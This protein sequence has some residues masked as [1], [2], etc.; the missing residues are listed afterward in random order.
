MSTKLNRR[1]SARLART[2]KT[3]LAKLEVG[4]HHRA[5][6][7]GAEIALW[8]R[9]GGPEALGYRSFNQALAAGIL[10]R[11]RSFVFYCLAAYLKPRAHAASAIRRNHARI[12]LTGGGATALKTLLRLSRQTVPDLGPN[13]LAEQ[14]AAFIT[15]HQ[16]EWAKFL[17]PKPRTLKAVA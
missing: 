17:A 7:L 16:A 2:I 13:T 8:R 1:E 11:S 5:A 3:K 12:S 9:Q 6:A 10:G 14:M 4:T 15:A